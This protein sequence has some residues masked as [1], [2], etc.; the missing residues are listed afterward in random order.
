MRET[1]RIQRFLERSKR[2]RRADVGVAVV[3]VAVD[4][5]V[6]G[7]VLMLGTEGV[8]TEDWLPYP[9]MM[10]PDGASYQHDSV[11]FLYRLAAGTVGLALVC[12]LW[13]TAAAQL[14]VLNFGAGF[15]GSLS[16][17]WNP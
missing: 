10:A 3:M 12:R 2:H 6:L 13:L 17:Y 15:I 9:G 11:V 1:G 16:T 14:V 8:F 5:V 4:L 7:W